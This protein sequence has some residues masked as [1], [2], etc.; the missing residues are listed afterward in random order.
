MPTVAGENTDGVEGRVGTK[1]QVEAG[2]TS[3]LRHTG[4][5]QKASIAQIEK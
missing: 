2:D 5:Y 3:E 4:W 1:P